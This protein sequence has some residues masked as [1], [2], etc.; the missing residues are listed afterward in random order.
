MKTEIIYV[1]CYRRDYRLTRILVASIRHWY[2]EIPISLV[3][4]RNMGNIDT[5]ELE[6]TFNVSVFPLEAKFYGWGFA[7]LEVFYQVQRKRFLILDSDIILAGPVLDILEQFDDDFVVHEEPFLMEDVYRWYFNLEELKKFDPDFRFPDFT[8]NTGQIMATSGILKREDFENFLE[9]T[10]PRVMK[11]RHVFTFGGEQP[12]L[13]YLVMKKMGEGKLTVRRNFFMREGQHPDTAAIVIEKIKN[14]T[15]YPFI[16]HWHDKKSQVF[17]PSMKKMPRRDLLLFFENLY[18][19][20]AGYSTA[21]KFFKIWKEYITDLF[22][23]YRGKFLARN[24]W[25]VKILKK[26]FR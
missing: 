15:G 1:P 11:Y 9:W 7:K 20:K 4:D 17:L 10:Q 5:S 22:I 13:N 18:Y 12:L 3:V 19:E 8:F 21:G 25:L 16:V 24:E 23:T 2:P 26:M 6:K 14:K